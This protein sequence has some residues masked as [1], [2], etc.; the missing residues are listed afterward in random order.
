MWAKNLGIVRLRRWLIYALTFALYSLPWLTIVVT[1]FANYEALRFVTTTEE[2]QELEL[3]F[4][5]PFLVGS[6]LVGGFL[7]GVLLIVFSEVRGISGGIE[8]SRTLK[9]VNT[10]RSSILN[11]AWVIVVLAITTLLSGAVAVILILVSRPT[12]GQRSPDRTFLDFQAAIYIFLLSLSFV[13]GFCGL[14]LGELRR[15][16]R[17][18]FELA[19]SGIPKDPRDHR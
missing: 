14:L 7:F 4:L 11:S 10:W 5:F 9:D 12:W 18:V 1:I 16:R 15:I 13:T 6:Y 17:V 2:L 8:R 19:R 3:Y